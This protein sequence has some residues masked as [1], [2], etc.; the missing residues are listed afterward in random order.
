MYSH[1]NSPSFRPARGLASVAGISAALLLGA[2]LPAS[3]QDKATL[4]LLVK[5]GVITQADADSV[6]KAA[7]VV[8]PKDA[9]VKK[10]QIEG[11]LQLQYDWITTDDKAATT[12][13]TPSPA[14][15][16]QFFIR[17]AYFGALADLGNGWGGEVVLD[18]AAT[19]AGQIS[20]APQAQGTQNLF[21]KVIIT[22][23]VEDWGTATAGFQKVQ[24]AFEENTPTAELKPLERSLVTN[25]FTGPWGGATTGRLGFGNRHSGL[26]WSGV[27]PAVDGLFY[28]VS[29][30]N[31]IQSTT[32]FGNP[33]AGVAA[34]N[35]FAGWANVGYGSKYGDFTYKLGLN[36]GYAG[37]ANSTSGAAGVAPQ[38]NSIWG[39]NPYATVSYA[40]FSL[41]GEFLQAQIDNGRVNG[42]GVTSRAAP[43]GFNLT[44]SYKIDDNWELVGR[45]SYLSTN[46]RG[47]TVSQGIR[48]ASNPLVGGAF[49]TAWSLYG[50]VTY[51]IIGNSLKVSAGYEFAQYS[52]RFGGG[53]PGQSF[54]GPRA[55]V[56]A[57]RTRIQLLF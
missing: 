47:E 27:V 2:A 31:G 16:N 22:K 10:L 37:D 26:Y 40:G 23:K 36:I 18:F 56:S 50:G 3:A 14:A 44:P 19:G 51:Y 30:T 34:Y 5:K 1:L 57:I 33:G 7:A 46:G 15:T 9:A 38:N 29:V 43:Y 35:E 42:A 13:A 52:D 39:Y 12:P 41:T 25:Y 49:D 20:A 55:N 24:Y 17:R 11:L 54:T 6:A 45:Y 32:S 4:D 8:A 21:E 28:G 53:T 48:N